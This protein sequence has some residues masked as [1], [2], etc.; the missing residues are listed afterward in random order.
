MP[1][2][3]SVAVYV[4]PGPAETVAVLPAIVTAGCVTIS[5]AVMLRVMVSPVLAYEVLALFEAMVTAVKVGTAL[6]KV[7]LVASVVADTAVP[8]LPAVSL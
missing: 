5:E 3:K 1:L 6:S 8:A 7:T 4:V 2:V